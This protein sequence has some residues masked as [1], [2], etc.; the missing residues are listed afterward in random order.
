M[1]SLII[2]KQTEWTE[3]LEEGWGVLVGADKQ[4]IANAFQQVSIPGEHKMSLGNGTAGKQIVQIIQ[5][6]LDAKESKDFGTGTSHR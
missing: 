2:D 5:Q 1:P 4:G 3:V 6:Y